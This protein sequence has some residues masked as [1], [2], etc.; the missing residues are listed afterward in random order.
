MVLVE[1]MIGEVPLR[2]LLFHVFSSDRACSHRR[3]LRDGRAQGPASSSNLKFWWR[4]PQRPDRS[5]T[6]CL[7]LFPVRAVLCRL[8]HMHRDCGS[9]NG[10]LGRASSALG[11]ALALCARP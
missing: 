1:A 7:R 3:N 8:H 6:R 10:L 9:E 2:R 4:T 5:V 11:A